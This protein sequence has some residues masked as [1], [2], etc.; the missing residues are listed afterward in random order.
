MRNVIAVGLLLAALAPAQEPQQAPTYQ[1]GAEE[2]VIDVVVRDKKGKPVTDL[3]DADFRITDNGAQQKILGVRMVE[4][5][6][7]IERGAKVPLDA[8]RQ[9]RLVTLAFEELSASDR[10]NAKRAA[11]DLVKGAQAQNVFYSVV[12]ITTKLTVLQPFTTDKQLLQRAIEK[13]ASGK[14][15]TFAEESDRIKAQLKETAGR[16]PVAAEPPAAGGQT[17]VQG[18]PAQSGAAA[19][20]AGSAAGDAYIQKRTAEIMLEML[21]FDESFGRNESTRLSIF[22]LLSLVRGQYSMPGRKSIIYFSSGMYV[23]THL[24]EPFRNV[25][26]AANRGNISFYSVD[27]RGV[28]TWS[29]NQGAA[30]ELNRATRDIAEDITSREGGVSMAQV[31][32][33]ERAEVSGRSNTQNAHSRPCGVDRGLPYCQRERPPSCAEESQRG[34]QQLLRDHLQPGYHNLRRF[35]P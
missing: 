26:S 22:S 35:L 27:T 30:E 8:M 11:L 17:A 32:A 6:E 16:A 15:M 14:Y 3:T 28:T 33:G 12:A 23:P 25:I 10:Q 2:V 34:R 7:A 19:G 9:I 1:T 21:S 4:G 5:A 29:Q 20:A 13:A 31:M 18:G 24:D